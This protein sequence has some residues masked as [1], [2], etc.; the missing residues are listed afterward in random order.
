VRKV[1][2][3]HNELLF[4][5]ANLNLKSIVRTVPKNDEELRVTTM[6]TEM[7]KLRGIELIRKKTEVKKILTSPVPAFPPLVNK[8]NPKPVEMDIGERAKQQ[9]LPAAEM[10][11]IL[12]DTL[13]SQRTMKEYTITPRIGK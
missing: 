4:K 10:L 13:K 1:E 11:T 2:K 12:E 9:G 3:A 8:L 5:G 6:M 7:K